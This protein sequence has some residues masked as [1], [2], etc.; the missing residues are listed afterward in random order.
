MDY[1][2]VV[3]GPFQQQLH[4]ELPVAGTKLWGYADNSLATP[5]HKHLGGLIIATKGR[6]VRIRFKNN[7]PSP[8]ILPVD[9]TIFMAGAEGMHNRTAV[10]L[11]GGLVPWYSDGGPYDW[12][13][14]D[15]DGTN[16]TQAGTS[17]V[18]GPLGPL[19]NQ[20]PVGT[21]MGM[22]EADYLY[23]NDKSARLVWYHDHAIGITRLNAYAGVATGYVITDAVEAGL[24]A[25]GTIPSRRHFL[26]FQDKVFSGPDGNPEPGAGTGGRRRSVVS[27]RL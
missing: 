19:D 21:K 11:H 27:Q 17:F 10:H 16:P 2:Q 1:Y 18:N 22:G 9:S 24:V 14:P 8:H 13:A 3:L 5:V 23:P 4:P 25:N 7:L 15:Y 12:W 6:P 20:Y 26:V